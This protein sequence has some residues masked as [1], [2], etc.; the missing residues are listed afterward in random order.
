MTSVRS[1]YSRW[2]A[3][4]DRIATAP[5]VGRWRRAAARRVASPG[6]TVVEMGCGTGANLPYL[7]EVVGEE[8]RVTGVDLTRP[9]LEVA[10]GRI[11]GYGNVEVV[12]GD[13]TDPPIREA[14]AVLATFVCGLFSD[15]AA[16]VDLWCDRLGPGGRI[17]LLD[18]TASERACGRP[19]TPAFRAFVAAGSPALGPADVLRAPFGAVDDELSRRIDT[20][21][22]ALVDRTVDRRYE[23]FGL[24]FVGLLTGTVADGYHE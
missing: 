20:A 4:Y 24:G 9:L 3:L 12:V 13:A 17:G 21:R 6:A 23:T 1:F 5:G 10:R 14:D 8:G 2:A 7:R 19:L 18:A 15:P 16:V 22:S 11:D